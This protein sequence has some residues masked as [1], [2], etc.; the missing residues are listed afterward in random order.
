MIIRH[1]KKG[2]RLG[3][4]LLVIAATVTPGCSLNNHGRT[5][6]LLKGWWVLNP[7]AAGPLLWMLALR[8][9]IGVPQDPAARR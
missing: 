5:D 1:V 6:C 9:P 7:V 8:G 3:D 2:R 4:G